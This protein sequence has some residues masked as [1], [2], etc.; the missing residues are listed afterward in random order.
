MTQLIRRWKKA[1]LFSLLLVLFIC[2]LATFLLTSMPASAASQ[3]DEGWTNN[4]LHFGVDNAYSSYFSGE[5]LI[6]TSNVDSLKKIMGIGCNDAMFSVYGGTPAMYHGKLI[7]TYAGGKLQGGNKLTGVMDWEFGESAAGW[8]PPPVVSED[9]I[10]YYLYVTNDASS[11]LFAVNAETGEKI[12][13]AATQ[14]KTGFSFL[15]Q[16]AIDEQNDLV[17]IV[18]DSFG[19][20]VLYAVNR[21]DGEVAWTIGGETEEDPDFVGSIVPMRNGKLYLPAETP[22]E[23]YK[24]EGLVRVDISSQAVDLIYDR[25][26]MKDSAKYVGQYGICN[27]YGFASF[28]EGSRLD[29]ATELVAYHLDQPGIAW[30]KNTTG[31]SGR[32]ACDVKENI[33]YIPT[34][35]S[36]MALNP[37]TGEVIWEHKSTKSVLSPTIANGVIYYLSDTNLYALDQKDGKQ[38]FRFPI[39]I[40]ADISTGVAINDGNVIFSGTGGDCDL[41]VLGLQ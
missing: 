38:L 29:P 24:R 2:A 8:A 7:I 23:H 4:W 37:E 31:Q 21:M 13:E 35:K 32:L 14:F 12:W 16:A 22:E 9:G 41:F 17:Y 40:Q 25:P 19:A 11:K 36:L 20:G 10:V 27:E 3:M 34:N 26:T 5:T 33:V 15:P 30:S 39:G 28:I 6:D 18:E 1:N